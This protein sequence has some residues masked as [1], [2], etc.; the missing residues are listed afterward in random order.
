MG[1][2]EVESAAIE[3]VAAL[4]SGVANPARLT[5]LLA[6]AQERSMAAV[7]DELGITRSGVQNHLEE[8][9]AR[10]L[11]YR[12]ASG[13][14]SYAVTPLGQFFVVFVEEH[15]EILHRAVTAIET[16]EA[17]AEEELAEFPV[18]EEMRERAVAERKWELVEEE[19]REALQVAASSDVEPESEK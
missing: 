2:D 5:I 14:Q 17:E 3:T 6:V 13:D 16:A 11:I 12:P 7:T 1:S 8:L 18:S 9:L 10:D 19:L 15:T 4:F